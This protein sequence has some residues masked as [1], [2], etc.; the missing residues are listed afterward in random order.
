MEGSHPKVA[1]KASFGGSSSVGQGPTGVVSGGSNPNSASSGSKSGIPGSS[2]HH[3]HHH[4]PPQTA[5]TSG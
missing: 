3:Q 1:E 5:S 4:A 2:H